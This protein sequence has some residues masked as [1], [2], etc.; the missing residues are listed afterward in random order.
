MP[1]AFS[2]ASPKIRLAQSEDPRNDPRN[3]LA[4][5]WAA[6][7]HQSDRNEQFEY[8]KRKH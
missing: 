2:D 3:D 1:Q 8:R 7:N 4:K 6:G 5:R